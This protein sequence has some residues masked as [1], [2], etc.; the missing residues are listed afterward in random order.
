MEPDCAD[1]SSEAGGEK[2]EFNDN[3]AWVGEREL[4]D[5]SR[6]GLEFIEYSNDESGCQDS[7]GCL[8]GRII[9]MPTAPVD[10]ELDL[11]RDSSIK[12]LRKYSGLCYSVPRTN[13]QTRVQVLLW[14]LITVG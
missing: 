8:R 3:G 13:S 7:R 12:P 10:N 14:C 4:S 2:C 1:D 5:V 9:K 6:S 11:N